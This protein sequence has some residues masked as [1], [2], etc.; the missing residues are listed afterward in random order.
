MPCGTI[1]TGIVA[2]AVAVIYGAYGASGAAAPLLVLSN[3]VWLSA[4][5]GLHFVGRKVL[6]SLKP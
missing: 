2:P 5:V 1:I 6:G 3:V 4:G